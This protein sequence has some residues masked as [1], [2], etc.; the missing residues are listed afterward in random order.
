MSILCDMQSRL[1]RTTRRS[2]NGADLSP[3]GVLAFALLRCCAA[4]TCSSA[5]PARPGSGWDMGGHAVSCRGSAAAEPGEPAKRSRSSV[6]GSNPPH[7][8][9]QSLYSGCGW[10][11]Y[12]WSPFSHSVGVRHKNRV[13]FRSHRS[14]RQADP[15][16]PSPRAPERQSPPPPLGDLMRVLVSAG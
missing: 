7:G 2:K 12:C 9:L 16:P 13:I 15:C 11:R 1:Q 10:V 4:G 8:R 6:Q 5:A 14:G 3:W